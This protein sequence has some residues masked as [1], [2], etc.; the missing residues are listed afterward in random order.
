[1]IEDNRI[2]GFSFYVCSK[3]QAQK[4]E[5]R[6]EKRNDD[7]QADYLYADIVNIDQFKPI[8][9]VE[10]FFY[11]KVPKLPYE[12][13]QEIVERFHL[14]EWNGETYSD[15]SEQEEKSVRLLIEYQSGESIMAS[16]DSLPDGYEAA[17]DAIISLLW[18]YIQ[19]NREQF[20][21][22]K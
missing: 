22:W 20:V 9:E 16:G 13:L 21:V 11:G 19:E 7:P 10:Y 15:S 4:F 14:A 12:E 6:S 3:D 2:N 5:W 1:M 17:E 18:D 8:G